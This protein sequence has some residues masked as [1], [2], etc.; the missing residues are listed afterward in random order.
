MNNI[1]DVF[2]CCLSLNIFFFFFKRVLYLRI[3]SLD[4]LPSLGEVLFEL[5][6]GAQP[7]LPLQ[8][9]RMSLFGQEH[10]SQGVDLLLHL[11]A[12]QQTGQPLA[13]SNVVMNITI[14]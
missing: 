10:L 4:I 13:G 12:T 6:E 5:V 8:I 3:R 9:G 14:V 7:Q 1:T 11:T 2:C